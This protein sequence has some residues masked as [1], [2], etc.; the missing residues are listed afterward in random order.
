MKSDK[1]HV[2]IIAEVGV[3]HNGSIDLAKRLA[4]K[5][6]EAGAD[7]VKYQTAKISSLVSKKAQMAEYQKANTGKDES[8]FDML[9]KLIFPFEAFDEI[10]SYCLSIDI[11][12]LS[13]PFDLE[14]IEYLNSKEMPFGKFPLVKL[15]IS[16]I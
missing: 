13:T 6:K 3:N 14:S 5:A 16:L 11:M 7:I 10:F 2:F 4:D 9:K 12:P 1:G 15:Q 8:Q